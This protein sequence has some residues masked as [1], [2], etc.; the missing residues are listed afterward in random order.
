MTERDEKA[1]KHFESLQKRYTTL[2]NGTQCALVETALEALREKAERDN[3]PPLTEEQ[4]RARVGKPVWVG[5]PPHSPDVSRR[6]IIQKVF[7]T[8]V[9]SDTEAFY[10]SELGSYFDLYAHEPKK[11]GAE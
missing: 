2:H 4:I 1:I 8:Y 6:A 9:E 10:F 3:N 11:D 5:I 7:D